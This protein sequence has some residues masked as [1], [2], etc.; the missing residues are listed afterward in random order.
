MSQ[1]PLD[2]AIIGV[3]GIYPGAGN[4]R[5]YWQN[6]LDKVDAVRDADPEWVGPYFEENATDDDRIYTTRGGFLGEHARVNP[7]LYGVMPTVA[8]GADPDHLLS[9]KCAHDAL[10][11]AG[12]LHKPFDRERAGVV[13]GRGTYGNRGMRSEEHTSELQ[14][15]M[16]ISSAVFC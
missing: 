2:I 12:Y 4:A 15:L 16:R 3:A 11:D 6:I 8:A 9:L 10:E 1:Q 7:Q 14:S 5:Q 13:V